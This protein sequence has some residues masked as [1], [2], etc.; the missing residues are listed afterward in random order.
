MI[1]WNPRRSE[2]SE[3]IVQGGRRNPSVLL[4]D[5]LAV[6]V[7]VLP[8]DSVFGVEFEESSGRPLTNEC[9]AILESVGARDEGSEEGLWVGR[10]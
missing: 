2:D 8:D 1:G 9:V 6:G 5:A 4:P 7:V 3:R 10:H